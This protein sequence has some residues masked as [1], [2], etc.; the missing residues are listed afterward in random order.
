MACI[1]C[2]KDAIHINIWIFLAAVFA[3]VWIEFHLSVSEVQ[4][5]GCFSSSRLRHSGSF[6]ITKTCF[7]CTVRRVQEG[8]FKA[9]EPQDSFEEP[10]G[11]EAIPVPAPGLPEGFQQLQWP[12]QAPEDA[13]WHCKDNRGLPPSSISCACQRAPLMV[14]WWRHLLYGLQVTRAVPSTA[15]HSEVPTEAPCVD[16]TFFFMFNFCGH[17]LCYILELSGVKGF[18]SPFSV[19]FQGL[20]CS[21]CWPTEWL[22][23]IIKVIINAS[24]CTKIDNV[25]QLGGLCH[26]VFMCWP[27]FLS[28]WP[29]FS[30]SVV[31][32][33]IWSCAL[34]T[35]CYFHLQLI[36]KDRTDLSPSSFHTR[37]FCVSSHTSIFINLMRTI[38]ILFSHP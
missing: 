30:A 10:H 33:W 18:F 11:G 36:W 3:T 2:G 16:A 17:E 25:M 15:E 23:E 26:T 35:I 29:N 13:S 21:R 37:L 27:R 28:S 22:L 1:C 38:E 6:S 12:C 8:L 34:E 7:L 14:G 9:W 19:A 4:T 24:G 32:T 20:S 31:L 5:N